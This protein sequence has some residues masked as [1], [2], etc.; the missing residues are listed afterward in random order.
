MLRPW[1]F[2]A[3]FSHFLIASAI[4]SLLGEKK[5]LIRQA[6]LAEQVNQNDTQTFPTVLSSREEPVPKVCPV[7]SNEMGKSNLSYD[8]DKTLCITE[9]HCVVNGH[10]LTFSG[11]SFPTR[12]IRH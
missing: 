7:Q 5:N 6:V 8:F 1:L 12:A 4:Y 10:P 3:S 9:L 11:S 2:L